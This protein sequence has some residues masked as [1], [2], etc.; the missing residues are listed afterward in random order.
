ML[1]IKHKKR[2]VKNYNSGK[3]LEACDMR[4][5]IEEIVGDNVL[6]LRK[7]VGW[8]QRKL[9]ERSGL[10]QR[11]ISNIEQ[12]GG[13]GSSSLRVVESVADGLGIPAFLMMTDHLATDRQKIERMARVMSNFSELSDHAQQRILEIVDDYQ[14]M[15]R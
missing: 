15:N 4:K 7:E 14:Q 6:R 10:S 8:S 13:A 12:G 11:V 3:L 9:A 5:P 1:I 2:F